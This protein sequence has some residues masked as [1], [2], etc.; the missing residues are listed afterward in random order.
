[1]DWVN[2]FL[3]LALKLFLIFKNEHHK[4]ETSTILEIEVAILAFLLLEDHENKI[5]QI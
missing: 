4:F 1:M 5:Q 3:P 2:I